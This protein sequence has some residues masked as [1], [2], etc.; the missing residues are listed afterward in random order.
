MSHSDSEISP[1][2]EEELIGSPSAEELEQ[3]ILESQKANQN[4]LD[5]SQQQTTLI[6]P[7]MDS[8]SEQQ[9]L[10][11]DMQQPS[12]SPVAGTSSIWS[13]E[14]LSA[15]DEHVDYHTKMMA[16]K[17]SKKCEKLIQ[18]LRRRKGE[19]WKEGP[20]GDTGRKKKNEKILTCLL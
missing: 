4:L 16:V 20:E 14:A 10:L 15:L 18:G 5:Y 17:K 2:Q 11:A 6:L 19:R 13:Q 1:S 12:I 8:T 9:S 3:E 7:N